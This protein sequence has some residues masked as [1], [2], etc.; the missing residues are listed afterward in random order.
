MDEVNNDQNTHSVKKRTL[1]V[2]RKN[3]TRTKLVRPSFFLLFLFRQQTVNLTIV[4]I[5]IINAFLFRRIPLCYIMGLKALYMK[6]SNNTFHPMLVMH[7]LSHSIPHSSRMHTR[8]RTYTRE[9]THANSLCAVTVYNHRLGRR[10]WLCNRF[11]Y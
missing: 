11:V 1:I 3:R 5:V 10:K 2:F 9:L 6:H 7:P 4:V 8:T